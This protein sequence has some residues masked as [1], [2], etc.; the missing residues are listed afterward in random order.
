MVIFLVSSIYRFSGQSIDSIGRMH[1]D[2]T[3]ATETVMPL[4]VLPLDS[5]II[6]FVQIWTPH[7]CVLGIFIAW[8]IG[9]LSLPVSSVDVTCFLLPEVRTF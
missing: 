7:L 4:T 3:L 8:R 9:K 1:C 6:R 2:I 5:V